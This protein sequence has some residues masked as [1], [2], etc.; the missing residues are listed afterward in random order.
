MLDGK[1][2][3]PF[4]RLGCSHGLMRDQSTG[5]IAAVVMEEGVDGVGSSGV[6][7]AAQYLKM[8]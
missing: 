2:Q 1:E 5:G 6:V 7:A 4:G 8:M 3:R